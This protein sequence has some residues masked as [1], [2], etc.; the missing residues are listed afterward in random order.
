M[1]MIKAYAEQVAS[2]LPASGREDVASEIYANLSEEFEDWLP[3]H[4]EANAAGFLDATK[5]HPMKYATQL[6]DRAS[7]WL[8]GPQF[9][10]S[11]ISALK[12]GA[13]ITTGLYFVLAVVVALTSGAYVRSFIGVFT[14]LPGTL[15]WVS[16]IILGVFVAIERSGEG[17]NW[18]D[19]WTSKDL[20]PIGGRQPISR[21][22]TF[23]DLGLST[24]G[25]LLVL[26]IVELPLLVRHDGAWINDWSLQLP[27]WTWWA[28]GA[29]FAW[30]I[31]FCVIRLFRSHWSPPLRLT[32]IA[33]NAAWV[34]LLLFIANQPDLLQV[35][36]ASAEELKD[37]TPFFNRVAHGTVLVIVAILA[38]DTISHA[39]RLFKRV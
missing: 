19:D 27:A 1:D 4:P 14:D 20:K 18:L 2:Y 23:F 33:T 32:T 38:W 5:P 35:T 24:L 15:L 21:V 11:F 22:E 37:V 39:W 16:A 30:D 10:F 26:N 9:Y 28:A 12:A 17:A 31:G 36:G 29:L 8:I 7:T 25:L 34:G 3:A 6:A 13:S